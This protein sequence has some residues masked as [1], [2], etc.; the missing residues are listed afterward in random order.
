M[1]KRFVA[2]A[3][4]AIIGLIAMT[5][6]QTANTLLSFIILGIIPGTEN[7]IPDWAVYTAYSAVGLVLFV[8]LMTQT[9]YIGE[10]RPV[11][12]TSRSAMKTIKKKSTR[13]A[14]KRKRPTK[15]QSRAA[16]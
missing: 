11:H 3:S 12:A 2:W 5:E 4:I 9:L 10:V 13:T 14:S 6:P 7:R 1:D 8:W 15:R 16:V